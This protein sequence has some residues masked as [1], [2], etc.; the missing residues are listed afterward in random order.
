MIPTEN[1]YT[2]QT[3]RKKALFIDNFRGFC[4]HLLFGR[5][6]IFALGGRLSHAQS[7]SEA[8][9]RSVLRNDPYIVLKNQ[10]NVACR[11]D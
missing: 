5:V 2:G 4:G 10:N 11:Q 7:C 3:K 9:P 8:M 6:F 1:L